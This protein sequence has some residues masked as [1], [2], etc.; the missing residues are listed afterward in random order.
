[1]V[2]SPFLVLGPLSATSLKPQVPILGQVS[3]L[4]GEGGGRWEK[5]GPGEIRLSTFLYFLLKPR[6]LPQDTPI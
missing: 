1:M 6:I 5:G 4:P 3:G 2:I